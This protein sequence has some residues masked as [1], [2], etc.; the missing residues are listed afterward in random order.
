MFSDS[1]FKKN[2]WGTWEIE[3]AQIY[4]SLIFYSYSLS[5]LPL[6]LS[7][8]VSYTWNAVIE[9]QNTLKMSACCSFS[10]WKWAFLKGCLKCATSFRHVWSALCNSN[11]HVCSSE[12]KSTLPRFRAGHF[13]LSLIVIQIGYMHRLVCFWNLSLH[14]GLHCQAVSLLKLD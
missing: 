9:K 4:I 3:Q 12:Q 8:S 10:M 5:T 2:S 13:C 14:L 1:A 7:W 6:S 11:H